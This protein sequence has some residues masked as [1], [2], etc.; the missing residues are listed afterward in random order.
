LIK[1]AESVNIVNR[2]GHF[3]K[4]GRS[5]MARQQRGLIGSEVIERRILVVRGQ[6]VML[7]ADLAKLY[8]VT[9]K[10]LNQ[11]VRRNIDRF[12]EDFMFE[13]TAVESQDLRSQSVTSS[14]HGGRRYRPYAFTE[15]GVAM[16]SSVLRSERAVQVNV[17]IMRTFVRL[18]EM[19][20]S[21]KD[22][23]AKLDALEAK[24]DGQFAAVFHA[25]RQLM[26]E[27]ERKKPPIGFIT[28]SK[29]VKVRRR[30][31]DR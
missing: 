21:H 7:D 28:E 29:P 9:T 16:L 1:L 27:R 6:K 10:A 18:R 25:L 19:L 22:L 31:S 8:G 20:V 2:T 3:T 5:A 24:Y 30:S 17:A 23:A 4:T 11:A 26:T 15:Q 13:L 12:P 14:S